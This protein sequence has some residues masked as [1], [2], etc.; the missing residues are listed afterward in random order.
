MNQS[1]VRVR[2]APSPTGNL[3]IGGLRTAFYNYLF[4]KHH[5]GDFILRIEDTDQTRKVDGSV[6]QLLR[7]LKRFD[8]EPDEGPVMQ[9]D[10]SVEEYGSFGPYV[11]S[12]RTDRY[13]DIAKKLLD[14]GHAYYCFCTQERL[15]HLRS[16]QQKKNLPPKY[17]GHCRKLSDE[18]IA[19]KMRAEETHVIRLKMP[20]TG[21]VAVNDI[22]RGKVDFSYSLVDEQILIK[23]DGFPTYHLANV[24]DDHDMQITHVIRG[25]EWLPSVPKHLFLYKALG[26]DAPQMAHLPILLSTD[27]SKLSKR[28]GAV[29]S[30]EYLEQG[31][32]PHALLNFLLLLG[33]NSKTEQE[34][35]SRKEMIE[36]FSLEHVNSSGAMVDPVKLLWMNKHY[37]QSEPVQDIFRYAEQNNF[38]P[39]AYINKTKNSTAW[40][41]FFS[42]VKERIDTLGQLTE[43]IDYFF[44]EPVVD[45]ALLQS[46]STNTKII[47]EE[48]YK[49]LQDITDWKED[50]VKEQLEKFI[51]E[52]SYKRGEVLWPLRVALTGKKFSPGTY[53]LLGI[54]DKKLVMLR[55]EHAIA[56]L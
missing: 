12:K 4:A 42:L 25:E 17:D 53:E 7:I 5:K 44:N 27:R 21:T 18:E 43:H 55:I 13:K 39:H 9:K 11:Q 3:H 52:K 47:L 8:I 46:K 26:W 22:V 1:R 2:F 54:F 49:V 34:I 35:F 48:S 41:E 32:L 20:R 31:Y 14:S 15:E 33:W 51:Q 24:V 40:I 28:K 56:L 16:I 10:G 38:I 30:E 50:V 6:E 19:E 45:P 29:S 37:L 36:L 23:S